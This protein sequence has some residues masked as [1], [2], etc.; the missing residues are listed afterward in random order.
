MALACPIVRPFLAALLLFALPAAAQTV[1][2]TVADGN[3]IRLAGRTYLLW[4][5]EAPDRRQTCGDGWPAGQEAMQALAGLIQ[6][7]MIDC[8]PRDKDRFGDTV[9]LCRADGADLGALMVRAGM[10]WAF[11][12]ESREYRDL[13]KD[14]RDD[15]RGLH[16][17]ACERPGRWRERH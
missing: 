17:H 16:D 11:G 4:G 7:H 1:Q 14:A 2:V 13:E 8:E 6:G 9:A 5:I 15:R 3:T 12:G 10:A